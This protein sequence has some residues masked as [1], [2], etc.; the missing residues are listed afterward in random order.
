MKAS[1]GPMRTRSVFELNGA[2]LARI[3]ASADFHPQRV[4]KRL[5]SVHVAPSFAPVLNLD[6]TWTLLISGSSVV[7][8]FKLTFAEARR[9][10]ASNAG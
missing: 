7:K 3:V 2:Q 5:L 6:T 1:E 8:N 9:A 4:S 10:G